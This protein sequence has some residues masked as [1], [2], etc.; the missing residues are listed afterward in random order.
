MVWVSFAGSTVNKV[1]DFMIYYAA[2]SLPLNKL[3][4]IDKQRELEAGSDGYTVPSKR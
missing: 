2:G 3:Y 1:S 4:N